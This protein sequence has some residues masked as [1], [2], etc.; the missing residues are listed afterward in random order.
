MDELDMKYPYVIL[1][2]MSWKWR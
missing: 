1:F 2:P